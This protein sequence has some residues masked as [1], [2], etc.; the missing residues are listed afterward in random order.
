MHNYNKLRNRVTLS[1]KEKFLLGPHFMLQASATAVQERP[2]V[3][4]DGPVKNYDSA[5]AYSAMRSSRP[6]AFGDSPITLAEPMGNHPHRLGSGGAASRRGAYRVSSTLAPDPG[7]EIVGFGGDGGRHS[8]NGLY[9]SSQSRA[10]ATTYLPGDK[11]SFGENS[12]LAGV[13][14]VYRTPDEKNANPDRLNLDRRHLTVCPILEGEDHLRLLNF[15]HN[16][17]QRMEHLESLTRLIFLD[18]Y[19]NQ[20][21]RISGLDS[22]RSLRVL[23]LGKNRIKVIENLESLGKLDVLDLHGNQIKNI[24]NLGHLSDLRVLNLAG[25]L[26]E[27][28]KNLQGLHLLTELNL[29]RNKIRNVSDIDTLPNLQRLF[30][31]FNEITSFDDISC[32]ADSTSIS[33]LSLDGNAFA[34]DLNYKQTVLRHAQQLK[35]L[36]MK[37]ISEDERRIASVVGRKEEEK[38]RENSKMAVLVVVTLTCLPTL[39][40]N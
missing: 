14:V 5:Q 3:K 17:I 22:L 20:I 13:P 16:L 8:S 21:D 30:L 32:V 28:A 23:M 31:S 10:L 39:T 37:R 15:Q 12:P 24:E 6:M 36:D 34:Q 7:V 38:K 1:P 25:N 26:I 27:N 35:Q 11:V 29:R 18:F 40:L 33:E 2:L 4:K 9:G 19:D